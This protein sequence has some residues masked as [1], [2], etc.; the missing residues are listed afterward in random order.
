MDQ[1][2]PSK[3]EKKQDNRDFHVGPR[4]VHDDFNNRQEVSPHP[5]SSLPTS[6]SGE[7]YGHLSS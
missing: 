6:T 7:K 2:K 3:K 5:S 4:H 1:S